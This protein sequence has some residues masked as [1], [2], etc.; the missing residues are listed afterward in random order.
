V[1]SLAVKVPTFSDATFSATDFEK[2]LLPGREVKIDIEF[3]ARDAGPHHGLLQIVPGFGQPSVVPLE[4]TGAV[5]RA[6]IEGSPLISFGR[7]RRRHLEHRHL[8]ATD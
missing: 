3:V 5:I 6:E 2:E 8:Q 1:Q 4:A 7:P